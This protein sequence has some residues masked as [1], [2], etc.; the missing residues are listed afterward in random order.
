MAQ[1]VF[2]IGFDVLRCCQCGMHFAIASDFKAELIKSHNWF[3]CPMGHQQ[4]YA[5]KTD[6]DIEREKVNQ[7]QAKA[8]EERHARLV[9]EK[10]L[11]EEK[12][13]L[14]RLKNRVMHGVCPCCNRTFENIAEHMKS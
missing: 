4:Q 7:V 10:A 8:N 3:Y 6:L 2:G 14:A 1:I 5:G 11:A 9:A 12:Q 13:E